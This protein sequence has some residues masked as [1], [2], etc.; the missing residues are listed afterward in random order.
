VLT[1]D[2]GGEGAEVHDGVRPPIRTFVGGQPGGDPLAAPGNQD[3]TADVDFGELRRAAD[4]HGLRERFYGSQAA[5]LRA[6]G[7][8]APAGVS[9]DDVR[10]VRLLDERLPFKV[11]VL[12]R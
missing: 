6:R 5:W 8:R 3:L 10:L 9:A 11:L 1:I 4:A 7:V 12:E 2:Y